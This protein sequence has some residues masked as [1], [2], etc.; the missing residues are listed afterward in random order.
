MSTVEQAL[1]LASRGFHVF[2]VRENGKLPVIKDFPNRATR[3]E[4][5][6]R[7]WWKRGNR[8]IGISCTKFGEDQA[9]CVVD[10][11]NKEGKKGDETLFGLELDGRDFPCTFEQQTP[12]GG[13]HL[14]YVT[15][16]PL[17]QGVDVL[18]SGID[19][20]SRGGYILGP[21]SSIDGK[22]YS[23]I[24][25][26]GTLAEAP[27]WLV[28]HLGA[29][30]RDRNDIRV[31]LAGIDP[32]RARDRAIKWLATA[33][34]AIQGEA[35]DLTTFKVAAQLKDFG[36]D[37]D[38][39]LGLMSFWNELCEPP[40]SVEELQDK[41]AHAFRY[42]AS[43]PGSSAPEAIFAPF[44]QPE[45]EADEPTGKHPFVTVNDEYAFVKQGAFVLHETT[46]C[47]GA[48]TT[49]HMSIPEFHA[50]FANQPFTIG[51]DTKPLSKWW[52][53]WADRRQYEGVVFLPERDPGPRW[54]NLWRGF[55]FRPAAKASHPSL[56]A[57]LEHALKNVCN[58]DKQLFHWLMGYFAHMIQRPWEK[59]LTALVFKGGK[60]VG[61]NALVERVGALLGSHFLVADDDRYLLGNFNS[62]L[63]SNLCFVLDEAAWAGDKRA[64][65]RLKGLIT[66]AQH[67]IERKGKEPYA[68]D[69]LTRVMILGNEEWLVPAS[70]DERRF[71]VFNVGEGRKQDRAFF[72]AMRVGMEQ[73]GYEH[74]LRFLLD[75][76]LSSVDVNDAPNTQ[77]LVEQKLAGLPPLPQ[78][79]FD[80][81]HSGQIAGGDWSG[82]WPDA[83][84]TNRLREAYFRW[85]RARG[86]RSRLEEEVAFGKWIIKVAPSLKKKKAKP[87]SP[88]G[89]T[90]SFFTPGLE[91]LRSDW[92]HYIG[93]T[94]EWPE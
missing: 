87:D 12:T 66:G 31:P 16:Q 14:V 18:G 56:D 86:I 20:R 91:R 50:W 75:F 48:F 23:Q 62:H 67:N 82:E 8:N 28:D 71:A 78:W 1:A 80:C 58:G 59:P 74:L 65:G 4:D 7:S 47:K 83:I 90:Y 45:S 41:V 79:W 64:E 68:I 37:H 84:P 61:K 39:T 5:Q 25:G 57:F 92:E 76:D 19:I 42:G 15:D 22:V 46:D 33:P 73:G 70:Q 44:V 24:N 88:K 35:G 53:S 13:R 43:A 3:N 38:M 29:D 93:G 11:D 9:L 40:W 26:H 85:A 21:G 54:Y 32:V 17:K 49:Q 51:E 72:E 2:P 69:N 94:I 10:V 36:C 81:V 52:M 55:R 63:E 30:R 34:V 77:A 6:I 89:S 27:G 60:G